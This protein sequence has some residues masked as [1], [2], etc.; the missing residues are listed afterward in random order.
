MYVFQP[1]LPVTV[2]W[3]PCN[4]AFIILLPCSRTYNGSL[5]P[6]LIP[7]NGSLL[8]LLIPDSL[9]SST[10]L[11]FSPFLR[12]FYN[13]LKLFFSVWHL[14][15]LSLTSSILLLLSLLLLPGTHPECDLFSTYPNASHS[16]TPSSNPS[17]VNTLYSTPAYPLLSIWFFWYT[18]DSFSVFE[19]VICTWYGF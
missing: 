19:W 10:K 6:P 7:N 5:L 8:P 16:S 11:Y 9:A 2:L 3:S 14:I 17:S 18:K 13:T 12:M 15:C 1:I 4:P